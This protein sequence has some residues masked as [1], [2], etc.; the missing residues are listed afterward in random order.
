V[1]SD[2]PPKKIRHEAKRKK[3]LAK[4]RQRESAKAMD[5]LEKKN[6]EASFEIVFIG[7]SN[8]GKST[9]LKALTGENVRTGKRPGV[10]LK[11]TY[12]YRDDLLITDMPGFGFMSG[13]TK[14]K[15]EDVK[16]NIVQYIE[17]NKDRIR[18]AV[19]VIDGLSFEEIVDRWDER[20]EIPIDIELYSFVREIGII[21]IIA[22]NKMDRVDEKDLEPLLDMIAEKY[23]YAGPRKESGII[24]APVSARDKKIRPLVSALKNEIHK[25]KRDDL[26][27]YLG[28][29][30]Q[31]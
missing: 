19:L 5:R 10:T 31:K 25:M 30:E 17:S 26:F 15:A 6:A 16:T 12:I 27:K 9:L 13:V 24:L 23:G 4:I 28:N 3:N 22:V 2:A 20:N 8:V 11:P 29:P 14:D 21:P 18:I 7:R 1:I